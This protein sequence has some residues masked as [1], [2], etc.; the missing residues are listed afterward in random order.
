MNNGIKPTRLWHLTGM[1]H[2]KCI[3]DTKMKVFPNNQRAQ[4]PMLR[5]YVSILATEVA[6]LCWFGK[7]Y[8]W[9]KS[10]CPKPKPPPFK[11]V[12]RT[13]PRM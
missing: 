13:G 7:D 6:M 9:Q 1:K 8:G 11:C 5:L 3:L 10:E 12:D 2:F 4:L